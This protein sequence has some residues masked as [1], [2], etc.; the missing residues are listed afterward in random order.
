[1]I[2]SPLARALLYVPAKLYELV[3]RARVAAYRNNLLKTHRLNAPV[4][5]VGNLTVG[6]TGK[7]PCVAFIAATLR[8]AGHRAAILSRGY[9]R[10]TTVRVEVSNHKQ[11]LCSPAESGDEPYLLAQSCPGVRVVVDRDR[12]AA[13]RW[14]ESQAPVSDFGLPVSVFILDDAYQHLRLARDLN[15][16]LVDAT[17]PLSEAKMIPFG[18]LREPLSELRRA[19][20]VIVT[21]SNRLK[22][23]TELI[24]TIKR[25]SRPGV[26]IFFADHRM[27]GLRN[28]QS[29]EVCRLLEFSGRKVA[30]VCG[31]AK[32]DR[33]ND[34]LNRA[35]LHIALRKDFS[36]HHRYSAAEFA[37]I[38]REAEAANAEAIVITE[39]DATNLPEGFVRQS[40]LPIFAAQIEFSCEEETAL[41]E[42]LLT[43]AKPN[44]T[45]PPTQAQ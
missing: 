30:A 22:D 34:D 39:K 14:L 36:D 11:I 16:L 6:G 25:I 17:E 44:S 13:G 32:P 1:M 41:R 33:F 24:E 3:V 21:R 35:G 38:V 10:Q 18:R 20:A 23:R 28:L 43:A 45:K 31:I 42:L 37:A 40:A 9:K 12:V 7:T 26:P 8:D 2:E 27:T 19:D 15:L 29:G 5:S 4:I